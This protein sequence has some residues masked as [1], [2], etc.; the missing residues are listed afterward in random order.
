MDLV[1]K[2]LQK[3]NKADLIIA[4]NVL[5]MFQILKISLKHLKILKR[6]WNYYRVSSFIK[7]IKI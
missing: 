6:G 5:H 2:L 3:H 7:F 4:N 1:N